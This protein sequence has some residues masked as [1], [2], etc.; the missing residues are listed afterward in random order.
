MIYIGKL[1]ICTYSRHQLLKSFQIKGSVFPSSQRMELYYQFLWTCIG[2]YCI[3]IPDHWKSF[4]V[5]KR[6]MFYL[7]V[8]SWSY[9]TSFSHV[10]IYFCMW[11]LYQDVGSPYS[12]KGLMIFL[13]VS[14]QCYISSFSYVDIYV[15]AIYIYW[16]VGSPLFFYKRLYVLFSSQLRKLWYQF[17]QVVIY[18]YIT[19][20]LDSQKALF[21]KRR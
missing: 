20:R 10:D 15:Y 5:Y 4:F 6:L 17:S 21:Y 8:S 3:N 7:P 18:L 11:Q 16:A 2:I 12:T 9:F 14:S 13:P 1:Y 19:F